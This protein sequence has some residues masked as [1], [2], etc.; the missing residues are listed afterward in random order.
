VALI[1]TYSAY[2]AEVFRAGI[3]SVPHGQ[4]LAARSLV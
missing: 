4:I 2:V 3:F 1:L